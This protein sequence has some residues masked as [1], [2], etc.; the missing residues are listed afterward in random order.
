M[1]LLETT[2]AMLLALPPHFTDRDEPPDDRKARLTN[3][4]HAIDAATLRATCV[5]QPIDCKHLGRTRKQLVAALITIGWHE[6]KWARYVQEGRCLD[7]PVGSRCDDRGTGL[8]RARSPWQ[9]ERVAAPSLWATPPGS[10]EALH[11]GAWH[12]ARLWAAAWR[13]C[14][15][16]APT[17]AVGAFAGYG[18]T[19]CVTPRAPAR[20]AMFHRVQVRLKLS[21]NS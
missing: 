17:P 8:P 14:E 20:A 15:G 12:A 21:V 2:L 16:R 1:T 5:N 18:G 4:A 6:S 9:I 11:E 7:G 10:P 13:R 3:V 19:A